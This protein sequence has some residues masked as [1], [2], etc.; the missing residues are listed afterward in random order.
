MDPAIAQTLVLHGPLIMRKSST[1]KR[2]NKGYPPEV[3][4]ER[5]STRRIMFAAIGLEKA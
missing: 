5:L 1:R 4:L 3:K 2:Q